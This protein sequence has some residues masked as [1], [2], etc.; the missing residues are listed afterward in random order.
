M[1]DSR[2]NNQKS[3]INFTGIFTE[4]DNR[5]KWLFF[6]GSLMIGLICYQSANSSKSPVLGSHT[7]TK[8]ATSQE[9][10]G[11]FHRPDIKEKYGMTLNY[12]DVVEDKVSR[13]D[14][15][16]IILDKHGVSAYD[17]DVLAKKEKNL[18][19]TPYLI[20]GKKYT[21]LKN[22]K[23]GKVEHFMYEPNAYKYIQYDLRDTMNV[24]EVKKE[25]NKKVVTSSGV[26]E[27]S[28]WNAIVGS[29]DIH[30]SMVQ[31]IAANMEDA[32][33]W[34]VDFHHVQ[35][36]DKFRMIFEEDWIEGE[37]V[38]VGK[39]IAAH[40]FQ[41]NND[42][43]AIRFKNEKYDGFF[44]PE[45]RPMK[46]NFLKA[47]VK[48]AR[49]S[50]RF[51][52][53]RFHPVLKRVKAHLGT[54][55]AAPKG[56]PIMATADGI[57]TKRSRTR[58]NGNFVKIKHDETYSTQYLHMSKFQK[59]VTVGTRVKQGQTIGYVGSTG[60]ATGPHVCYRF[61]KNGKQVD[62]K[63]Q[64]LPPPDPLPEEDKE[65]FFLERDK[66][67]GKL[68]GIEFKTIG[69]ENIPTEEEIE[70][71]EKDSSDSNP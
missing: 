16:S 70:E 57:V 65:Q 59:G 43:Y 56:T 69:E 17:V 32:L 47:P 2:S 14:L 51:N 11:A 27:S 61:W 40:F 36:G 52:P 24:V 26:I 67:I 13:N 7:S 28:L 30:A 22:K 35:K 31:A 53:R 23:T 50:S 19:S 62:P 5:Q 9:E 42:Y 34:S 37:R 29:E 8:I 39:L 58:G 12:F 46:K 60:L 44:D 64:N 41:D 10:I 55:F 4:M 63:R 18:E 66:W 21:I 45:G 48:Y 38:G 33:Q 15:L 25:V 68:K 1:D 3:T 71:M 6:I 49:I 54:D 20:P